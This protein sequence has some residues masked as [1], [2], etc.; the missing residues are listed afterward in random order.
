MKRLTREDLVGLA[1]E[2]QGPCV[3]IYQPADPPGREALEGPIRYKNLLDRAED[4]LVDGGMKRPEAHTLLLGAWAL[5]GDGE[6]HH[7]PGLGLAMFAAPGFFEHHRLPLD[8]V[9]T[10]VVGERF[11]LAPLLPMLTGDGRFFVLA[12]SQGRVRLFEGDRQEV[13]EVELDASTPKSLAEW[14]KYDEE[15]KSLQ[16]H[17]RTDNPASAGERAGIFY[18]SGS[19]GEKDNKDDILQ[20]FKQLEDSVEAKMRGERAPLVLA[21]VEYLLPLYRQ[22]S[23]YPHILDEAI[24]GNQETT[25]PAD[26]HARAWNSWSRTSP[27]TSGP[28]GRRTR[29]RRAAAPASPGWAKRSGPRMTAASTRCS[30]AGRAAVG[31]IRQRQA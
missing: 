29:S 15:V 24:T 23:G 10:V 19:G 30:S 11:H 1:G 27:T 4:A 26:L 16:F 12:L 22:A 18:G 14:K 31:Q 2:R 17:T 9:E 8:F 25:S 20:W 6:F 7:A 21:G 3:T 28:P 13:R 5:H